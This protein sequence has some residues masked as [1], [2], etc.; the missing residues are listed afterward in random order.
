M[1]HFEEIANF[2]RN[3]NRFM[4]KFQNYCCQSFKQKSW[5]RDGGQTQQGENYFEC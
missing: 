1:F 4:S 2:A 5:N 3:F